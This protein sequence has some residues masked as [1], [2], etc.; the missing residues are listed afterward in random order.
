MVS[1]GPPRNGTAVGTEDTTELLE[2]ARR[3]DERAYL[4]LV[5]SHRSELHAHCYRILASVHDADDAVQDVLVRAWRGLPRF[6]GRSSLRTWL[7]KIATNVALDAVRRRSRRET[8]IEHGPPAALGGP[9]GDAVLEDI[10]IEPY[11][12]RGPFDAATAS[13]EARYERRESLELAFVAALQ[14]LAPQQRAVLVLREV[15]GFPASDVAGILDTSV[16]AVNSALQRAR[17]SIRSRLPGR[18]QH[19]ELRALGDRRV[20]RLAADYADAI[21]RADVPRLLS[22]LTEDATWAMPPAPGWY[23]GHDAIAEFHT[24]YVNSQR[25]R[26]LPT[27]ANGQLAIGCYMLE[28]GA[29]YRGA[30]IDVLTL[31]RG[32]IAAVMAFLVTEAAD[33]PAGSY[34][35]FT[36]AELFGRFGLPSELPLGDPSG[37]WPYGAAGPEAAVGPEAAA[38]PDPAGPPAGDSPEKPAAR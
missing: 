26:H 22:M 12:G 33:R 23:R 4:E 11:P 17:S 37:C 34:R 5:E 20:A 6:E 15:L 27:W 16:P 2:S 29:S 3:G 36:S 13:P 38:E 7:F 24:T 9:P 8:P 18:S 32:R 25:W 14:H 21:E 19:D 31:E 30:V 35:G 1:A 28:V 10:W